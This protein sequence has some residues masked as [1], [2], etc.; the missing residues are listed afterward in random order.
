ME[1]AFQIAKCVA[2]APGVET[3]QEWCLWQAEKHNFSSDISLPALKAVPPMQRR[4]LSP[5][6]K[7]SLHCALEASD[8]RQGDLPCVFSSRHGDLNRTTKLIEN[9]AAKED[10]SPTQ[11]GLSVHNAVSG[12]YSIYTKN[13]API[14]AIASGKTSFMAG[15]V[16]S[17][18]KLHVNQ[19][20]HILYVYTDLSV[21]DCY[22]GYLDTNESVGIGL[23]I[24]A[25]A[26]QDEGFKLSSATTNHAVLTEIQ[27]LDFLNFYYGDAI[28]WNT[29]VNKQTWTLT[30]S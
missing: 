8:H 23:L 15:L 4:R 3:E 7:V 11:F 14:S 18:V 2:W 25:T 22:S 26:F 21:P 27:S 1:L 9:V 6:A 28:S 5:F 20:D 24:K 12:L 30:K 17:V 16:D 10:L 19:L 13:N 29:A